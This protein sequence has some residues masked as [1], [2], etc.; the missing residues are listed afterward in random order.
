MKIHTE[1]RLGR[2]IGRSIGRG[3]IRSRSVATKNRSLRCKRLPWPQSPDPL[4]PAEHNTD[5]E[6]RNERN[7]PC[8][9]ASPGRRYRRDFQWPRG[10]STP[11]D[12]AQKSR[13]V[14]LSR[15]ESQQASQFDERSACGR[16]DSSEAP[17]FQI[18]S[19]QELLK[20]PRI[21]A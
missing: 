11:I 9:K 12:Q 7:V 10:S 6:G 17:Q 15:A 2:H 19:Q 5:Q 16:Q 21:R 4:Q 3:E 1:W 14:R 18:S 8:S 13:C 20:S